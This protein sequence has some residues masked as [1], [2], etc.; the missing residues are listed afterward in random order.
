MNTDIPRIEF[1]PATKENFG[2]EIISIQDIADRRHLFDHDPELPHQLKFYNLILFTEG[3]GKH[4]IDFKW[5]PVQQNSLIYL[6]KEQVNAF[7]FSKHVKGICLIFSEEFFI[8]SFSHLPKDF[9]FRLFN[10]QLFSPIIQTPQNDDFT[11]YLELLQAEYSNSN[12][13]NHTTILKSLFIILLSKAEQIKQRQTFHITDDTRIQLF[14]RFTNLLETHFSKSRSAEFYANK[15][16]ISYKHLNTVCK[17]LIHKTAK[18]VINDFIIL[19]AQRSLIN[20]T[21]KSTELAYQL[22]FEDP[23]NFTKYFKKYTGLTPKEFKNSYS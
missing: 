14:K 20:S 15:L 9:V 16:N 18:N 22:G 19:Q 3:Q 12:S 10:P 1:N 2:F 17:E 7:H 6:T 11:K 5:Y 4:F 13:F 21:V 23:T 8:T